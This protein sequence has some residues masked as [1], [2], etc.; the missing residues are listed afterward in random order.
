M[1][2][3]P[4]APDVALPLQLYSALQRSTSL[5]LYSALHSTSSYTLPQSLRQLIEALCESWLEDNFD[6]EGGGVNEHLSEW[7][8]KVDGK[9]YEC[10]SFE[11]VEHCSGKVGW[12]P[13]R[14]SWR[15]SSRGGGSGRVGLGRGFSGRG[16]AGLWGGDGWGGARWGGRAR[17]RSGSRVTAPVEG[18]AAQ[19]HS[20]WGRRLVLRK[21][22]LA[23]CR[24]LVCRVRIVLCESLKFFCSGR[25][26]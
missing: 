2:P 6:E 23:P 25:L 9:V 18:V 14:S 20:V 19:W 26:A 15:V 17:R 22:S 13:L 7:R 8:V 11:I 24:R 4:H 5:Q 21:P 10:D 12:P 16:G 1:C 3:S